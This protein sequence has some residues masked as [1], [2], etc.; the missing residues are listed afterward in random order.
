MVMVTSSSQGL[1]AAGLVSSIILNV[2]GPSH[3]RVSFRIVIQI[4]SDSLSSSNISLSN[5]L[6]LA[7]TG[8]YS[9]LAKNDVNMLK[10]YINLFRSSHL[11]NICGASNNNVIL[12]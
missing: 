5:P 11:Q 9:K 2:S 1:L 12:T 4:S 3:P 10:I 6:P 7:G 8:I